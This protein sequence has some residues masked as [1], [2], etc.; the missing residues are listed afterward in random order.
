MNRNNPFV[1]KL[2]TTIS[3]NR[4]GFKAY[5]PREKINDCTWKFTLGDRDDHPS[6][7]HAH[8]L[9][10]GN[11]LNV[12]TGE[13]YPPGNT[14][15]NVIDHLSRKE[16]K[17]IYSDSNFIKFAKKQISWYRKEFPNITF[18]VPEWMEQK[19]KEIKVVAAS[20]EDAANVYICSTKLAGRRVCRLKKHLQ[21]KVY[22]LSKSVR[23]L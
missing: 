23:D 10:N 7:P 21:I 2:R 9:E 1:I 20:S 8:S 19:L 6:V 5:M 22:R 13:I 4:K 14:R 17:L 15:N 16:L 11:R 3:R 18:Y 12:W